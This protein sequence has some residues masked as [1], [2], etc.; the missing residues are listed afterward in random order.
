MADSTPRLVLLCG[1]PGAGKTTFARRLEREIRAL[2]LSPDEWLAALGIDLWDEPARDKVERLQWE[3]A[4]RVVQLGR[5]VILENGYWTR[6]EREA[7]RLE[8][9]TLGPEVRVE[10][11]YVAA[12]LDELWRRIQRRNATREWRAAPITRQNLEEWAR[13]FEPPDVGELALYDP[14]EA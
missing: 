11:H 3:L 8:A 5:S 4:Q 13:F 1:L 14:P 10:L 6:A 12:P 9:R 2:R 7:R